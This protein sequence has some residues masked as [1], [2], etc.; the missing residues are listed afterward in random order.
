[1]NV[2]YHITSKLFSEHCVI[3]SEKKEDRFLFIKFKH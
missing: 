2:N 1:M 3:V